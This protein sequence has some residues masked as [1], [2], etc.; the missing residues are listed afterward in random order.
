MALWAIAYLAPAAPLG[1][2]KNRQQVT[3]TDIATGLMSEPTKVH[4]LVSP[5][6][7]EDFMATRQAK[8]PKSLPEALR[9]YKPLYKGSRYWVFENDPENPFEPWMRDEF[10]QWQVLVYDRV[11]DSLIATCE[12]DENGGIS[13]EITIGL[14]DSFEASDFY[15]MSKQLTNTFK[16]WGG[17]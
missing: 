2:R 13:G 9:L 3:L 5:C 8:L 14:G 6:F 1:A 7:E 12:I 15:S 4:R 17:L 10:E 11:F 16:S